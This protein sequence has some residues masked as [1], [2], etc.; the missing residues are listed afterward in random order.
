MEL[1]NLFGLP[2]H[3]L[4]VH[5]PVI[6]VPMAGLI[7]L[8]FAWR[9]TWLDRFGWVLVAVSGI[10]AVGAVLAAGSGEALEERVRES[11]MLEEHAELGERARLV[12]L[13]FFAIVLVV[14]FVRTRSKRKADSP[15]AISAW[16]RT[17]M[18]AV[19]LAAALVVS[20]VGAIYTMIEAGHQG[21]R[22]TWHEVIDRKENHDEPSAEQPGDS[23]EDE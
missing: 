23:D 18:G 22:T 16:V 7:A 4:L 9:T 1:E 13:V 3:P 15:D 10:G 2:A 20:S 14:V 17:R 19:V 11:A 5:L 12:A 21:A 6:F 8:V